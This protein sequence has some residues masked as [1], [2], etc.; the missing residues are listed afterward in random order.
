MSEQENMQRAETCEHPTLN[1]IQDGREQQVIWC[2][3]CRRKI[4]IPRYSLTT[5]KQSDL[6][7]IIGAAF[8]E[9]WIHIAGEQKEQ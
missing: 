1:M 9:K 4:I 8:G 6:A 7:G 5:M 2:M 3:A